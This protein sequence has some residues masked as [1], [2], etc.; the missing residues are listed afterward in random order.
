MTHFKESFDMKVHQTTK[1]RCGKFSAFVRK[2]ETCVLKLTKSK[3]KTG[4]AT[5]G[6]IKTLL[7]VQL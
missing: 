6:L 5:A 4:L 7:K 2:W 3:Q 1:K